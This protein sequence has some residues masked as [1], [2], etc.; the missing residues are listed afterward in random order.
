MCCYKRWMGER[1]QY[2]KCLGHYTFRPSVMNDHDGFVWGGMTSLVLSVF[3][4]SGCCF[5]VDYN[6][7]VKGG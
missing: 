5:W 6:V 1:I 7:V 4:D 3:D 2:C